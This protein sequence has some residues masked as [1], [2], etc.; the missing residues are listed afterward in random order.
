MFL[1]PGEFGGVRDGR[2]RST[3]DDGRRLMDQ[4]IIFERRYHKE[5]I[6][7]AA[8]EVAGKNGVANVPTPDG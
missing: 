2:G 7:Y 5:G 4:G 1:R 8:G 3:P 6:V